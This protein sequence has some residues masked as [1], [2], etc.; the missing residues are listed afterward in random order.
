MVPTLPSVSLML[1][2]QL[3]SS[4]LSF[5]VQLLSS[6][7]MQGRSSRIG[8]DPSL[9]TVFHL[10]FSSRSPA[11]LLKL[12]GGKRRR[13]LTSAAGESVPE[14]RRQ[15]LRVLPARALFSHHSWQQGFTLPFLYTQHLQPLPYRS[16]PAQR[17]S[18]EGCIGHPTW[19]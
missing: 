6:Q 18:H 7:A 19:S 4:I 11:P 8:H 10:L 16:H 17:T 15:S 5:V 1:L 12:W 13:L 14:S 2:A 3:S 9:D